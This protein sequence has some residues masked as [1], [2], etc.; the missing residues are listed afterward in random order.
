VNTYGYL[1]VTE[2]FHS[3]LNTTLFIMHIRMLHSYQDTNQANDFYQQF[4]FAHNKQKTIQSLVP[5]G[6]AARI[7]WIARGMHPLMPNI[8]YLK[9]RAPQ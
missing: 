8:G 4:I 1:Y 3:G 6:C 9:I 5:G 7:Q 2:S